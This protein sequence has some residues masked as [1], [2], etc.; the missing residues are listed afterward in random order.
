MARVPYTKEHP[1][2]MAQKLYRKQLKQ[3]YETTNPRKISTVN[4]FLKKK[5]LGSR[6]WSRIQK[7]A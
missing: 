7:Y 2:K 6:Y 1:L 5:A 3:I 4:F